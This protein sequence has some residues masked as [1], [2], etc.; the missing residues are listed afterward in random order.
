MSFLNDLVL[1]IKQSNPKSI[2]TP[3]PTID[4]HPDHKYTTY[5][6][7]EAIKKTKH[8]AKIL[9][10]TNHLSTSEIY[11]I[12]DF[13]SAITLPPNFK[14]FYFDSIY[15]FGLSD[16][17]QIDKF[18]ALEAIHDLRDS[19]IQISI[20]KAYKHLDRLITRAIKGKDKSYYK[21]ALRA[22]ELFFVIESKNI[23]KLQI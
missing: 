21:R 3:H 4:S 16:D 13:H 10:Y 1:I 5:A 8:S 22:N 6:L 12:G 15:S 18:F 9:T 7:F 14:E 11:P 19:T 23:D 20:K 17:L 2:L